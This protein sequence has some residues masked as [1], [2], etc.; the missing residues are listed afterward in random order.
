MAF[1]LKVDLSRW[2]LVQVGERSVVDLT[3][4][5]EL[6]ALAQLLV[7]IDCGDQE[8]RIAA[9]NECRVLNV[10]K[11]GGGSLK[12]ESMREMLTVA[13]A[14][15]QRLAAAFR[16]RLAE[17]TRPHTQLDTVLF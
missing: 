6:C 15:A 4:E 7:T 14:S 2:L 8:A 16:A 1:H 17:P 12:L 13:V 10:R 11:I 5:E 9:S 3:T